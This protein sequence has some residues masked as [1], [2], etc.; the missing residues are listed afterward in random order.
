MRRR[1]AHSLPAKVSGRLREFDGRDGPFPFVAS[2]RDAQALYF[3]EPNT[4]NRAGLAVSQ[5]DGFA[6]KL[7]LGSLKLSEDRTS[8]S[9]HGWHDVPNKLGESF[10]VGLSLKDVEVVTG[11]WQRHVD[12][13]A[14]HAIRK[15]LAEMPVYT[16]NAARRLSSSA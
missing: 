6:N 1:P 15:S 8:A 9:L 13:T 2:D 7:R 5:D 14:S 11:A 12:G 10:R 4:L 16:E 3:V